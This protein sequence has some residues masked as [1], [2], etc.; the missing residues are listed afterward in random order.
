MK[1]GKSLERVVKRFLTFVL[2][3][4]VDSK[5]LSADNIQ[6]EQIRS[7]LIIRQDRKVGNLILT[8]PLIETA[9]VTFKNASIDILVS[10]NLKVLCED[11]PYLGNIYLFDHLGFIK[12][13]VRFFG[14]ISSLRNNQYTLAIES[15][16]PGGSS[17]L[18]GLITYLTRAKFRI[19]F[20]SGQG[21]IFTNVH[22]SPDRSKHY[23]LIQQDL[24]NILTDKKWEFK[25]RIF[26]SPM[27]LVAEKTALLKRHSLTDFDKLVGIWI[28]ARHNKKWDIEYFQE[29]YKQIA[30]ETFFFP[31]LC[32]GIEEQDQ[33]KDLDKQEYNALQFK[34]LKRLKTFISICDIFICGDTGPLHMS[35]ALGVPTIGIFLQNNYITYGYADGEKNY[36]IKP[37][38]PDEMIEEIIHCTKNII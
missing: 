11:N 33:F 25:P 24:V 34:D 20:E 35:F 2:K 27:V 18:N 9:K 13:P 31:I 30:L 16:N 1:I 3:F 15:S 36:I 22:V 8:T 14:L 26:V 32:F 19:G 28:G 21:A 17:F 6:P 10:K 7:V 23:Y 37:A 12:N 4:F 29:V 5:K 38:E